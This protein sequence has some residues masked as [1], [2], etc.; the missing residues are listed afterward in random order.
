MNYPQISVIILTHNSFRYLLESIE[1]ILE[2]TYNNIQLIISDDSSASFPAE[3]LINRLT[4]KRTSNLEQIIVH[5]TEYSKGKIQ[6]LSEVF[7]RYCNGKYVMFMDAGDVFYSKTILEDLIRILYDEWMLH[8]KRDAL[9][10]EAI[11]AVQDNK[12]YNLVHDSPVL[13]R[14][15][16]ASMIIKKDWLELNIEGLKSYKECASLA[17][18]LALL[19]EGIHIKYSNV[20]SIKHQDE[21]FRKMLTQSEYKYHCV[22]DLANWR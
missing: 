12:A 8:F 9:T 11:H 22:M 10:Q 5:E 21:E 6:Q 16:L 20:I 2:Q 18:Q 4:V 17:L 7:H 14:L 1:S 15:P 3:A 13:I 19:K